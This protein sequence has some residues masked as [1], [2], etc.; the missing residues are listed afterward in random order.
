MG[1]ILS[2]DESLL[3]RTPKVVRLQVVIM[4]ILLAILQMPI[5]IFQQE[6]LKLMLER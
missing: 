1:Q 6:V 5:S 4:S 3:A 2:S